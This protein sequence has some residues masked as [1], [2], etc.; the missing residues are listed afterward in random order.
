LA[1]ALL[2]GCGRSPAVDPVIL[3]LGGEEVRR[4]DFERYVSNVEARQGGTL[5]PTVRAALLASYLEKRVLVLQAR[6]RGFINARSSAE[7]EQAAVKRLLSEDVHSRIAVTDEEV[8]RHYQAHHAEFS[9]PER[10]SLRQ[11]LVGTP[12]EARDALRRLRKDPKS[13]EMLAQTLSRGPEAQSGGSMGTFSRGELPPELEAAAFSL[14][15]GE[16][17]PVI[18]TSLGH[19]ILRVDA[20]EAGRQLTLEDCRARIRALL[21]GQK[22][23][24]S[25][26]EF[27]AGLMARAKVNN[28]AATVRSSPPS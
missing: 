28:E 13:F 23:E 17:S 11:I 22:A 5:E 20:V 21:A 2:V 7:E 12:N 4:S 3:A 1:T 10:V 14:K 9:L 18:E 27:I 16:T 8:A 26:R 25:E 15:S 6:S 24:R 19:H